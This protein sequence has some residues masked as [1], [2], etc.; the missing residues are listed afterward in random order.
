MM[1]SKDPKDTAQTAQT[2]D[3]Q[4]E[5]A[6][7]VEITE[8]EYNEDEE[9]EYPRYKQSRSLSIRI[10]FMILTAAICLTAV[11]FV[12]SSMQ[13]NLY[14]D[15][16]TEEIEDIFGELPGLLESAEE[17]KERNTQ[18]FDETYQSIAGAI[19][20]MAN[21]DAGFEMRRSKMVEY[22]ELT[23]VDNVMIVSR[24][25]RI[26]A[27]AQ[28]T[29]ANFA[30]SRFNLLRETFTTGGP[31]EE[32]QI[33]VDSRDWY[34]RYYAA[35][36]DDERM[37][38]IEQNANELDSLIENN[39]S[40]K[41]TLENVHFGQNGFLFTV[42]V[43]D[44]SFDYYPDSDL[45]GTDSLA[46][47][48]E[49]SDLM[50]GKFS[51][52]TINGVRYYCG[53][54]KIGTLYYVAAVPVSDMES[55][56]NTTVAV[57]LFAFLAVA[58]IVI[59]YGIFA[60]RE[61]ERQGVSPDEVVRIG[62]FRVN[63]TIVQ[64]AAVLSISGLV[65]ILAV[66]F[67]MQTLFALSSESV[68]NSER[69]KEVKQTIE[70]ANSR[71][72]YLTAQYNERYLP[73]CQLIAYILDANPDLMN[74]SDLQALADIMNVQN[75]MIFDA[76][77][78]LTATNSWYTGYTLSDDPE[79]SSYEFTKLLHGVAEN[80][81]SE[82]E[83][84]ESTGELWQYIGVPLHD[85]DGYVNALVEISVRP[86][87]IENVRASG[88]IES[89]MENV[90]AGS[91]GFAFAIDKED[92]TFAYYPLNSSYVGD[93]A[94]DHGIKETQLKDGFTDY[95]TI[96]GDKYYAASA[97]TDHYY[98]YLAD[99]QSELMAERVPLTV[100]TG[101][102]ALIFVLFCGLLMI[103]EPEE[104]LDE[105]AAGSDESDRVINV[106]MPG[107]GTIRT[108][109]AASRWMNDNYKWDEMTAWQKTVTVLRWIL[110]G[111]M[112]LVCVFVIFQNQIFKGSSI[113]AYILG[114]EWEY[115]L[116]IFAVSACILIICAVT[117][118]VNILRR[119]LKS[120]SKI[121]SARGETICRL[122]RSF[123]NYAMIIGLTFYCLLIIGI[124]G[125]TLLASA[126]I[127]SIAISL[128][129]TQLITDIISG[130][131]II[132]EGEFR[133]GDIITVGD[134]RGTVLEIGIRTTKVEDPSQNVKIIRNSDVNNVINMT[135]NLSFVGLE[136]SIE[137]GESLERV[138]SILAKELPLIPERL[139]AIVNGPFYK[140]V[141]ELGNNSVIIKISMQCLESDRLQLVRDFNREI[142]LIFDKYNINIPFPQIVVNQPT[143][144]KKATESEKIEAKEFNDQQKEA[145]NK[146]GGAKESENT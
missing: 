78:Q 88:T 36:I 83:Y 94:A 131:F 4:A 60:M 141:S 120:L 139:P 44:Y 142:K 14:L 31:S 112:L 128:G 116:N 118:V 26:L 96:D 32:V 40:T 134:W 91:G 73:T 111:A 102:A 113:F 15:N 95:L 85:E 74:R 7:A 117:T 104:N 107:G 70:D 77:E 80:V 35:A 1:D 103:Y 108:E 135:K 17:N 24:D 43:K 93:L 66:A 8:E 47:G 82:P 136:F 11:G 57:I 81:I 10:F 119:L 106:Q 86:S 79:D 123:L 28:S 51:W 126:G 37:V 114:G 105:S 67:Y 34:Y 90:R 23:H 45:S 39:G 97:E 124:D 54:K 55:T 89:A 38:V 48:L 68:T 87:L 69:A 98:I 5:A 115:G 99:G 145:A 72:S 62:F 138:E 110:A 65:A 21:H 22:C 100:A 42:S 129:A 63:R 127:L 20:F 92:D 144:F 18:T 12:I 61:N 143:K 137:Y 13:T 122:I 58:A 41:S 125:T 84:E 140:G 132:F 56:R 25:G 101:I 146:A 121:L 6:E 109:S 59:M 71:V 64:K 9:E 29:H 52:S 2:Q 50:D 53:V 49:I 30:S 133:V 33:K 3:Q 76:D 46:A 19:A 130:L 75:I 27:Q 16:Y